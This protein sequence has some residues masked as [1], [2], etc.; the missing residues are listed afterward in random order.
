MSERSEAAAALEQLVNQFSDPLSFF[1]ELIQNAI[2]AGSSEVEI[3]TEHDD[4][5]MV[6]HIDDFGEGMNREIIDQRLTRL[7]SSR[8]D[9]DL[10]KIGK[11]GIGFVSVF[12]IA[13][14]A[15]CI[16]TSRH[17]ES[18]RVLF[19]A[20]RS[21]ERIARDEPVEGTKISIIKQV[22][23]EE[24]QELV[25]RSREVV[26]YWCKFVDADIRFQGEQVSRPFRLDTPCQVRYQEPGTEIVVGY[27]RDNKP[28]FGFYNRGLTLLEGAAERSQRASMI[29]SSRYLE[30]TLARDD[31]RQDESYFKVI[32]IA[33]RL[34]REDLPQHLAEQLGAMV[35]GGDQDELLYRFAAGY[36]EPGFVRTWAAHELHH[37]GGH[38]E[39]EDWVAIPGED[40]CTQAAHL[41]YGPYTKEIPAGRWRASWRLLAGDAAAG[42]QTQVAEL[43]VYAPKDRPGKVLAR[44]RL[45]LAELDSPDHYQ[46]VNLSFRSRENQVIELRTLWYGKVALRQHS[47][48]VTGGEQPDPGRSPL[49]PVPLFVTPSGARLSVAKVGQAL[50]DNRLLTAGADSELV[51]AL[52]RQGYRVVCCEPGSAPWQVLQ[53]IARGPVTDVNQR[54]CMPVLVDQD[55]YP[56]WPQLQAATIE[57]LQ[58]RGA[59]LAGATLARFDTPGSAISG[60]AAIAQREPGEVSEIAEVRRLGRGLLATRRTL[61][62]NAAHPVVK[63][64]LALAD[65]EPEL[66]AYLLLKLFHTRGDLSAAADAELGMLCWEQRCK[67]LSA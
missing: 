27:P 10:T 5:V 29:I 62:V 61:V 17:G 1:R 30:H 34:I 25:A 57:M 53:A 44:C 26:S 31:V 52:E 12:A 3:R 38:R 64:L 16:D 11:F 4:G 7:F 6:I 49:A 23:A 65:G 13:P 67:R 35:A 43:D 47:V 40:E 9:G 58:A 66:A 41:V 37:G 36:L 45:T 56:A 39:G 63:D 42:E 46:T 21:F 20:D 33:E 48:T 60:W 55:R 8:K 15:V 2:D 24:Y 18:W 54:Y 22:N 51:R 28:T 19:N 59:K 14:D 50:D 32:R